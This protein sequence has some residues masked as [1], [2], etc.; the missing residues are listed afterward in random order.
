MYY[1]LQPNKAP[2]VDELKT[3]P[4]MVGEGDED[5]EVLEN[6]ALALIRGMAQ[7]VNDL[8]SKISAEDTAVSLP[9]SCLSD[10]TLRSRL[11]PYWHLPIP[12]LRV[13]I[14]TVGTR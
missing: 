5:F 8:D 12:K 13:L 10:A 11:R 4:G 6:P 1:L 7:Q 2:S 3:L 9:H 14:M